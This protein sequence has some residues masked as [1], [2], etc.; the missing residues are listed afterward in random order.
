[1]RS[2][3]C[4]LPW[5]SVS[6]GDAIPCL[7]RGTRDSGDDHP[8]MGVRSRDDRPPVSPDPLHDR[9]E[10]P[11]AAASGPQSPW[12][13]PAERHPMTMGHRIRSTH[14]TGIVFHWPRL[15]DLLVSALTFHGR[16]GLGPPGE[17]Q[18]EPASLDRLR[19]M[20][21]LRGLALRLLVL[22]RPAPAAAR[23]VRV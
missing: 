4:G 14:T 3:R 13:G 7:H 22:P 9:D 12:C 17:R 8:A 19:R 21:M 11:G 15:Y 2:D 23:L 5:R 16:P 1:G 18:G 10:A 6:P 20:R